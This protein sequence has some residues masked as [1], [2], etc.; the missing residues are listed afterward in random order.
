MPMQRRDATSTA[1]LDIQA[2][3]VRQNA[4]WSAGHNAPR[5]LDE[6]S[7]CIADRVEEVASGFG[8]SDDA[9]QCLIEIAALSVAAVE[10]IDMREK[11]DA[12]QN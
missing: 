4:Q 12:H 8:S 3:Q 9:R 5:N 11:D 1:Y 6:F 10:L 7:K 2:E